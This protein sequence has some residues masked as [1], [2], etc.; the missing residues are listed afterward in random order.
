MT[1]DAQR[2]ERAVASQLMLT[3]GVRGSVESEPSDEALM[4]ACRAGDLWAMDLLVAR[5]FHRLSGFAF[6]LL[7]DRDAA[8]DVA[9]ETLLRAYRRA[10]RFRTDQRLSAWLLTIAANLCRNEVR[11]RSRRP[12]Y[13]VE[14]APESEAAG[15]VEDLALQRLANEEASRALDRLSPEHRLTVVLF[16]YEGMSHPEIA[17]LCGCAV[18][19]AKSRLH[20]ALKQLRALLCDPVEAE[21]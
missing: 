3:Q 8:E 14:A 12:E 20:Y 10:D 2:E 18:G 9:Q 19:T 1:D 21:R 6:R 7:G 15:S 17:K 4:A 16:Y 5:Y 11:R 13:G